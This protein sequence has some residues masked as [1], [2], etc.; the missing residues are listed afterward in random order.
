MGTVSVVWPM[1]SSSKLR[2]ERVLIPTSSRRPSVRR[3]LTLGHKEA[4]GI[5]ERQGRC[6]NEAGEGGQDTQVYTSPKYYRI[7]VK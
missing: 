2:C 3:A 5:E 7:Q 6:R 4:E 1:L